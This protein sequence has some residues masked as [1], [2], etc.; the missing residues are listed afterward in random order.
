MFKSLFV[1]LLLASLVG[2]SFNTKQEETYNSY[3]DLSNKKIA[4]WNGSIYGDAIRETIDNPNIQYMDVVGDMVQAIFEE[5][6]V[7]MVTS[8]YGD[9]SSV[10][11][12][13]SY[14][15]NSKKV[16]N[17]LTYKNLELD[18]DNKEYALSSKII[19]HYADEIRNKE[20]G[21]GYKQMTIVLK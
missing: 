8:L 5:L 10:K 9:N 15:Q 16:H 4:L 19:K 3:K 6:C 13:V 18:L 21:D 2:C 11:F 1:I 20:L 14:S 7:Q 12:E 17:T